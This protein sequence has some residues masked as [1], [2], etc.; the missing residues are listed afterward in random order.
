MY[1]YEN[2][3]HVCL[4]D[5]F[6]QIE[7][8]Q[9]ICGSWE[10]GW[11]NNPLCTGVKC[12]EKVETVQISPSIQYSVTQNRFYFYVDDFGS[13]T[14]DSTPNDAVETA[15]S[16]KIWDLEHQIWRIFS[17]Y[18]RYAKIDKISLKSSLVVTFFMMYM[19]VLLIF[20]NLSYIV[21]YIA[22][23]TTIA[24]ETFKSEQTIHK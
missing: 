24:N 21:V 22:S 10:Q 12:M 4:E 13:M 9:P 11:Y 2:A 23:R 20:R 17:Y 14:L 7:N 8:R 19:I 15:T 18:G 1:V 6:A 16:V 3:Q 5:G